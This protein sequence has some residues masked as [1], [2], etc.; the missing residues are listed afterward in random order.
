MANYATLKAAIQQ[1]IKANGNE[2]IT[3]ALLQQ[4]LLAMINSLGGYYQF[5]GIATPSTNPGTPD[6]NVFYLASTAGTYPNFGSIV[7]AENEAAI[8]KYNGTWSKDSSG[9]ATSEKVNQLR[10]EVDNMPIGL[11]RLPVNIPGNNNTL[12]I[13][14][15]YGLL[16]NRSYGIDILNPDVAVSNIPTSSNVRFSLSYRKNGAITDFVKITCQ[17]L[18][19][20]IGSHYDITVPDGAEY[21]LVQARCDLGSTLQLYVAENDNGYK[22]IELVGFGATGT[23]AGA[24]NVGDI[25]YKTDTKALRKRA[26]ESVWETIPY[27][28]GAI[29]TC[30]GILYIW[31]GSDLVPADKDTVEGVDTLNYAVFGARFPN[32]SFYYNNGAL[33]TGTAPENW[34]NTDLIPVKQGDVFYFSGRLG[35]SYA[36]VLG[37]DSTKTILASPVILVG[38]GT[39]P[40][41][42]EK[43]TIPAGVSYIRAQSA[44][45]SPYSITKDSLIQA[46]KYLENEY[47]GKVVNW[48]GDSIVA[49]Q[50]FDELVSAYFGMTEN[51]YGI[52]GSTIAKDTNDTRNSMAVRYADMSNDADVIVVSGGTNDYQYS[53]TP[54]GQMGDN[55][56]G[57]FYGALDVLCRGLITKYPTKVI[58]FTTPIKRN[59]DLANASSRYSLDTRQDTANSLGKYL[60]DYAEAIKEV[61]AKY[62]IPVCD[63]YSESLLN[64]NMTAQAGYF[65]SVGTHPNDT[66]RA[67][68]ARRV[69]GF[70]KQLI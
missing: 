16:P 68:M 32:D 45:D 8:L 15:I 5:A 12:V 53:F 1:V 21:V 64:P 34:K 42:N 43:I 63:L 58:F 41:S 39:I 31:D 46:G 55:T 67:I 36:C 66:G 24:T 70:M 49:D 10:Q 2:E 52:N 38:K 37:Y 18:S 59:Q 33:Y 20:P 27:I 51:D 69:R 28:K 9:F 29:Y 61:C 44:I 14:R 23:E 30:K 57:T 40:Y 48:I 65:D 7:I 4:S 13:R 3:G 11:N 35:A 50:D 47:F 17:N 19:V 22:L 56:V 25:Y 26:S 62:S 60:S 6:Q 54:F